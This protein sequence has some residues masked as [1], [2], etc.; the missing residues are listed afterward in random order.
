ML[1]DLYL[2]QYN[3]YFNRQIRRPN[4]YINRTSSY[5]TSSSGIGAFTVI[6]GVNFNP[7]DGVTT[8]LV[9]GKGESLLTDLDAYDYI[10]VA[11]STIVIGHDNIISRWFIIDRD[12]T[13]DGQYSFTL[14]RD[15]IVDNLD[16]VKNSI[17]FVEK[18]TLASTTDPLLYNN[19]NMTYNQ[20]KQSETLLKDSTGCGW[21]VGYIPQDAFI[22]G[23]EHPIGKISKD[24]PIQTTPDYTVNGLTSWSYY[25]LTQLSA[26]REIWARNSITKQI[27]LKTKEHAPYYS[28]GTY[29]VPEK[30]IKGIMYV[31]ESGTV[32]VA[33]DS[34]SAS[35]DD[36]S[37]VTLNHV[38]SSTSTTFNGAWAA[39]NMPSDTTLWTYLTAVLREQGN[40]GNIV[41]KQPT[42]IN[43]LILLTG[44]VIQDTSTGNYY[45]IKVNEVNAQGDRIG[46]DPSSAAVATFLSRLNSDIVRSTGSGTGR[47]DASGNY[48]AANVEAGYSGIG[49]QIELTQLT[50]RAS[51]VIDGTRSHV[52][53][54][55]YDMFCI[56]YSDTKKVQIDNNTIVPCGKELAISIAQEIAKD[57][58]SGAIYD[59]QLLPYCPSNELVVKNPN[60]ASDDATIDLRGL[61]IDIIRDST[62]SFVQISGIIGIA[63]FNNAV[64]QYGQI[65][66]EQYRP[67]N[68]YS[69][70]NNTWYYLDTT[71]PATGAIIWCSS[72]TRSFDI[73]IPIT[74]SSDTIDRKVEAECEFYRLCSGNYQGVFEFNA[75]KSWGVN[76]FRVDC[77][78]KPFNPYI[79]VVPKLGG[80]Y[81]DGFADY[82]DARGLICGGDFSLAQLSNAWANYELQNKNYQNIFDRQIQNMDT[83]NKINRQE[84]AIGA[85]MG[86]VTSAA[87]SG[88]TGSMLGG[89][90]GAAIGSIAGGLTG[91][92]GGVLDYENLKK[93]QEEA[94]SFATDMYG[95]NLGNIKA[96]PT[97]LAKNTALTANTKIFPFVEKYSCTDVEKQV[98]RDK[99]TYNGMTVMKTTTIEEFMGIRPI[100]STFVKGQIIRLLGFNEDSHMAN[101]IYEEIN[102]GVYI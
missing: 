88:V 52:L 50:T 78:F 36:W 2:I 9:L 16:V 40:Y 11:D 83:N 46:L 61:S 102:K 74:V 17:T 101:A 31:P 3:N 10:L 80:L 98:L 47:I 90:V 14:K 70:S 49:Y 60:I 29:E 42:V 81:G 37:G 4:S 1:A 62:N 77:T 54:A 75:A 28:F 23:E 57:T 93:R 6:R 56:P 13:R 87:T 85:V 21:V 67:I 19:E 66:D 71:G 35:Y 41:I 26:N 76:G 15:V 45:K 72:A 91:A 64:A 58:G 100:A 63:T 59:T 48:I 92:I 82:K 5:I 89:G 25:D 44:K 69:S 73:D 96:I 43:N 24:V 30:K 94:R 53:D 22:G 7:A 65:Y 20:I 27:T 95:Y 12:R 97:S 79:H 32:T 34:T 8:T 33:T 84:A 18:A 99:M 86:T 38:N 51:V 55:P 39:A 68:Y